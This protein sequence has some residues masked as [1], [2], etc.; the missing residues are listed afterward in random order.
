MEKEYM[1]L[2]P[3]AS[4][5]ETRCMDTKSLRDHFLALDLFREG[6]CQLVFTEMDR[7][8]IGG[9]CPHVE[10]L[11]LRAKAQLA[12]DFFVERREGGAL[13]VGKV[14]AIIQV[15]GQDF[16]LESDECLYIGRGSKDVTFQ[17]QANTAA[18][19]Y[20]VSFPA[21]REYPTRKAVLE[22]ARQLR[23]G[24]KEAR[25]ERIIYQYIHEEGIPSCQLVMGFT[26]ILPGSVW[27][28]MPPHTHDRRCEIYLYYKIEEDNLVFH[29][30]GEP[31]ATRHLVV[32]DGEAALSPPWSIHA[33]CGTGS[34]QFVW[35]M[36][37]ENQ[38]FADMDKIPLS[39]L[40]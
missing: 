29:F 36:G 14:P 15:D 40:Q 37:G 13:N 22:N 5:A 9:I 32:R 26:K 7:A 39:E 33:G 12:S 6:A 2:Q 27:N 38:S 21:H 4:R 8:V 3:L 18:T 17:S 1:K 31:D 10:P 28:T 24:S 25:N 35:A 11:E 34:Y 20:F 16:P 30:M 23:L 19:L